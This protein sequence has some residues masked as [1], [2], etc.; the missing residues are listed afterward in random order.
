MRER[1]REEPAVTGPCELADVARDDLH[2]SVV[3]HG[4]LGLTGCSARPDD[5]RGIGRRQLGER[6]RRLSAECVAELGDVDLGA[7]IHAVGKLDAVADDRDRR[8]RALENAR[9]LARA[10]PKVDRGR[11]RARAQRAQVAR[12]EFDRRRQQ[13]AHDVARRHAP[14]DERGGEAVGGAVQPGVRDP[15]LAVHVRLA[16]GMRGRR[17]AQ[18]VRRRARGSVGRH[19]P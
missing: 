2:R 1:Q 14:V 12:G 17:R 13:Q 11:D 8:L 16:I 4:A 18:Q 7:H 19:D 10:E 9:L 6:L 3:V 5:A 15:L